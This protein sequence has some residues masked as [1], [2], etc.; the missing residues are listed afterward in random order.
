[1]AEWWSRRP[2]RSS[3]AGGNDTISIASST[4]SLSNIGAD[5]A[6]YGEGGSDTLFVHNQNGAARN[7]TLTS[8]T[9]SDG[10]H[11]YSYGGIEALSI[12]LSNFDETIYIG[13]TSPE[14]YT[15]IYA[16][17]G[18]DTCYFLTSDL[19]GIYGVTFQG[20]GGTDAA[21]LN[22]Q[23]ATGIHTYAVTASAISRGT[24]AF[25]HSGLESLELNAST[26]ADVF[27]VTGG[28]PSTKINA[29]DG[30]DTFTLTDVAGGLILVGGGGLD[31]VAQNFTTMPIE[32]IWRTLITDTLVRHLYRTSLPING[33]YTTYSTVN[34]QQIHSYV[35][36]A[37]Y[38][39]R[40]EVLS[41]PE[42]TNIAIHGP[43]DGASFRVGS[44]SL[45]A[46]G[47]G[48]L[49]SIRGL[50]QFFGAPGAFNS[51]TVDD[52]AD[53]T[54]D[55]ARVVPY[56]IYNGPGAPLFAPGGSVNYYNFTSA[57][58]VLGSGADTVYTTPGN[59][60][61][62]TI[63]GQDPATAQP[64][65]YT[66]FEATAVDAVAPAVSAQAFA[67]DGVKPAV[68]FTFSEDV[69]S[70]L[71]PTY[72]TLTNLTTGQQIPSTVMSLA[73]DPITNRALHL[74][75]F[76]R[77]HPARRQLPRRA[78]V[79]GERLV[80]QP[81]RP[82]SD[83]GLFRACRRREPRPHRGQRRLCDP[84]RALQPAGDD[85]TVGIGDFSI[86]A[87]KFNISLPALDV[88]ARAG[89][90]APGAPVA[91]SPFSRERV[92]ADVLGSDVT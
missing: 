65:N 21:V 44:S 15:T 88:P 48:N 57:T 52:G 75:G 36:D 70:Q 90:A 69:S 41:T 27:N 32:A 86:L 20:Q 3:P 13:T 50:L 84:R 24:F 33:P 82:G 76:A 38:A 51:L 80:W 31:S 23:S 60:N 26:A 66:G 85:G 43:A 8:T 34:Y 14:M 68:E 77:R 45:L 56:L 87:S 39:G 79:P 59:Q 61:P 9:V 92:V 40:F 29:A 22:D 25:S 63:H 47:S 71:N 64:I 6:A 81:D 28:G 1:M 37:D 83:A 11:T 46:A 42:A 10:S 62:M 17:N 58:I 67:V 78:I 54:G 12:D 7:E 53:T 89:V 91:A 2:C 4:L 5:V 74:P 73:Y 72:L 19:A 55:T 35:I 30:N 16:N 18:N 49:D